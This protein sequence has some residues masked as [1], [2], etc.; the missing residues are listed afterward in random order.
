MF[1]GSFFVLFLLTI[2]LSV[3]QIFLLWRET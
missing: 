1:C 2:A 3:Q